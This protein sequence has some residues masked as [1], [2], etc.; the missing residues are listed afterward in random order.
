VKETQLTRKMELMKRI[1]TV[2]SFFI[3]VLY[4][5]IIDWGMELNK[6]LI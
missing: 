3:V 2:R 1:E 5:G 6:G 4:F